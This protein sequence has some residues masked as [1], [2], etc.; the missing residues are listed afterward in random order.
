MG[1]T[2]YFETILILLLLGWVERYSSACVAH[3]AIWLYF[4][5]FVAPL[6]PSLQNRDETLSRHRLTHSPTATV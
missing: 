4:G 2:R 1:W 3:G 5:G 6:T